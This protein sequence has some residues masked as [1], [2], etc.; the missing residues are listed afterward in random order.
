MMTHKPGRLRWYWNT[1]QS[2]VMLFLWCADSAKDAET[3]EALWRAVQL[4]KPLRVLRI[5]ETPFP[6]YAVQH[7]TDVHIAMVQTMAKAQQQL[8]KWVAEVRHGQG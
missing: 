4:D 8:D 5:D 3:F 2:N 1:H 7:C 6:S